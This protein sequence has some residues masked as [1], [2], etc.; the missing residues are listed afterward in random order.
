MS[1]RAGRVYQRVP[2]RGRP[3]SYIVDVGPE[4]G[5]RQQQRRHGFRTRAEAQTALNAMLVSLDS[6][7]FVEPKKVTT[8]EYLV[9]WLDALAA[10]SR[11][12]T[13][14][15]SYRRIVYNHLLQQ[16]VNDELDPRD[17]HPVARTQ[18]QKLSAVQ[19]DALYR[20]LLD[21]GRRDGTGGLSRRSV[22]FLHSVIHR[23]LGDA[24]RK[25]LIPLNPADAADAPTARDAAAP[26]ARVWTAAEVNRFLSAMADDDLTA[27]WRLDALTGCRRGEGLGLRWSDVD[28]GNRRLSIVQQITVVGGWPVLLPV[29]I[30]G[31]ARSVDIGD[32]T[33]ESLRR[34]K[35]RQAENRLALGPAY[36]ARPRPRV[37]HGRWQNAPPKASQRVVRA[38]RRA[39]GL[40][41]YPPTRSQTHCGVAHAG[42]GREREGRA[43]TPGP[44]DSGVHDAALPDRP[45]EHAGGRG[46]AL[47]GSRRR[48]HKLSARLAV[49]R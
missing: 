35:A 6:G 19:L 23:A 36:R 34:H 14:P 24:V 42:I 25:K 7:T 4:G 8:G 38:A 28:W 3:W 30:D 1:R 16:G 26:E 12:P 5:P 47:R 46:P 41:P 45:T 9:S 32:K 40:T 39:G 21:R 13:T 49:S 20:E 37:L 10:R 2:G 43:G 29:K 11:K 27:L 18:L 48:R 22:R 44:R 31:S 15:D 17:W 33:L